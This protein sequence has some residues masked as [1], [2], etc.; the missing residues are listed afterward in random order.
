MKVSLSQGASEELVV[1]V[2][3]EGAPL[4]EEVRRH[5]FEPYQRGKGAEISHPRGLGLGLFIVSEIAR[6][7]GGSVEVRSE[8][9][10]GTTFTAHLP[11][12]PPLAAVPIIVISGRGGA[13]HEKKARECGALLA[14]KKPCMPDMM[15]AAVAGALGH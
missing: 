15:L 3:N 8:E 11:K 6:A 9:G 2:H 13:E 5:V 1:R 14:L 4:P 7:H 12:R 10:E